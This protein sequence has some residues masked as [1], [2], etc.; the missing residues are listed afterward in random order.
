MT[1]LKDLF[2]HTYKSIIL[3]TVSLVL[4]RL[5]GKRTVAQ[6]SPFDLIFMIIMGSAIAIPLEDHDIKIT[7]G[8]FPIIITSLLNYTLAILITKNRKVENF[9][10]GTSRVLVRNGEVIIAN[11]KKERIT[12]ADLLI[13]LREKGVTNINEVEEAAIEPNG[14]LSVIKK[15]YMQTVTPRDLGLWSNQG[16]FPTLVIEQGEVVQ[17]NL[18]RLGVSIDLM[19]RQLN[20]KGIGRLKEIR[21]AWIDEEGNVS[22]ERVTEATS[23]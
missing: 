11:L 14:K 4:V 19:L 5:M 1:I 7:H 18:D 21:S 6:L 3:F 17:D 13:L 22:V 2:L 12:M 16:I 23:Q 8:I 15:K 20:Q 10:Q 9:L